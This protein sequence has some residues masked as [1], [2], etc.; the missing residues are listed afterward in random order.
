MRKKLGIFLSL[1]LCISMI[2][3]PFA[4]TQV[5][6]AEANMATLNF[7]GASIENGKAIFV[8]EDDCKVRLTLCTRDWDTGSYTNCSIDKNNMQVDLEDKD[9]YLQ[10][11]MV[12][13]ESSM[14][15]LL[16]VSTAGLR[17]YINNV[18][19]DVSRNSYVKID[20]Y[21]FSGD[22]NIKITRETSPSP[23]PGYPDDIQ[24]MGTNDGFGMEIYLNSAK[25]GA[26]SSQ[27]QG[28]GKGYASGEIYNLLRI[29]LAFGDGDIGTVTVN[30]KAITLPEGTKDTVEF[31]IAPASEYVIKVTKKPTIIPRTIIWA[32]DKTGNNGLKDYELLK[33][34]TLEILEI[35][36]P[37]G[38]SIGLDGVKQDTNYGWASVIPSSEIILRAVPEYGYQLGSITINGQS[39]TPLSDASTFSY[40]MPDENVHISGIFTKA[41]DQVE[42]KTDKVKK[43]LIQLAE[44]EI[45]SGNNRL[46]IK[47]AVL[48]QQQLEAFK[49]AAGDYHITGY[50]DIKLAQILYKNTVAN[51]WVNNIET[52]KKPAKV[53][54]QIEADWEPANSELAVIHEKKD[55]TY[56]IIPA[57]FDVATKMVMFQTDG[58]SNYAIAYKKVETTTEDQTGATTEDP[59]ED[60][61]G[62][63]TEASTEETTEPETETTTGETTEVTTENSSEGTTTD[64]TED[65]TGS[66]T[67]SGDGDTTEVKKD[68]KIASPKTG[69]DMNLA[70]LYILLAVS[71]MGCLYTIRK[72]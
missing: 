33:N 57:S 23:N 5:S 7:D 45:T 55:G 56:E 2:L 43:A 10:V 70:V 64:R 46:T 15:G 51:L 41:E 37:D 34:G 48:T 25:I 32:K 72:R 17:L 20:G 63:V 9:Y 61:T 3:L 62:D 8:I 19:H 29:Q 11:A 14:D 16:G 28:T 47:D 40:T 60:T 4:S 53:S 69:D 26:E 22:L 1:W 24:I 58:F 38:T 52:L 50:F 49:K 21:V 12:L 30:G 68:D 27:I 71:G 18:S 35:K 39:L 36:N 67:Q 65:G 44:N 13:D 54:L 42:L 31:T 6:A 59:S 66:T